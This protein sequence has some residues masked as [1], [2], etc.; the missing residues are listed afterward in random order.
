MLASEATITAGATAVEGR[1]VFHLT[2]LTMWLKGMSS[3]CDHRGR[4]EEVLAAPDGQSLKLQRLHTTST[5]EGTLIPW[6][7][8]GSSKDCC[9]LRHF[10]SQSV[11][12]FTCPRMQERSYNNLLFSQT[13]QKLVLL[14][15]ELLSP[16]FYLSGSFLIMQNHHQKPNGAPGEHE[17][18]RGSTQWGA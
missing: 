1:E 10:L 18:L 16:G 11:R 14:R 17:D 12:T 5:W 3:R 2:L 6:D 8:L 7:G 4:K 9:S 15:T 13:K